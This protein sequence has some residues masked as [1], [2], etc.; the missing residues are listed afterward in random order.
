MTSSA[1]LK[2]TLHRVKIELAGKVGLGL[3]QAT[4]LAAYKQVPAFAELDESIASVMGRPVGDMAAQYLERRADGLRR[5]GLDSVSQVVDLVSAK[6]DYITSFCE[7]FLGL[8]RSRQIKVPDAVPPGVGLFYLEYVLAANG[9]ESEYM[10][11]RETRNNAPTYKR[12]RSL[13]GEVAEKLGPW[14]V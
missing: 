11:W 2:R 10:V 9:D 13:N 5:F 14:Q 4:L 1:A 3:D 8:P 6:H 7:A 12:L